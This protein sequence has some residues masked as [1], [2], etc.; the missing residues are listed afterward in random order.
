MMSFRILAVQEEISA[1]P[2]PRAPK[3]PNPIKAKPQ[4]PAVRAS[5]SRGGGGGGEEQEV[6]TQSKRGLLYIA[7]YSGLQGLH[8]RAP[9]WL[10][11]CMCAYICTPRYMQA[12]I[13]RGE[14]RDAVT[15]K[16]IS[17]EG[18]VRQQRFC[19]TGV[20]IVTWGRAVLC[21]YHGHVVLEVL[22]KTGEEA[23]CQIL[24]DQSAS[25]T[26]YIQCA[27]QRSHGGNDP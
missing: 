21:T 2:A 27:L 8:I 15:D 16:W 1:L 13:L 25:C 14:V 20:R 12:R 7:I 6:K 11:I 3:R 4:R 18:K 17:L 22:D 19:E 24:S 10:C 26:W 9:Q 5:R 23:L